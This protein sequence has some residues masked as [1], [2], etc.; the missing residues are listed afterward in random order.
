MAITLYSLQTCPH[1][2][3]TKHYLE[4]LNVIFKII[5]VDML[6]GAERND[7]LRELRR[8]NPGVTFPTLVI[9]DKVIIGFKKEAIDRAVEQ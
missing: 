1:C 7:T 4:Q 3:E 6:V 2:R 8:I 9:G 5:Y